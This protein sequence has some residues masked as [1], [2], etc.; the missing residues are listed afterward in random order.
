M[1]HVIGIIIVGSV[2]LFH[3]IVS[4]IAEIVSIGSN[5]FNGREIVFIY[6]SVPGP[7]YTIESVN[8]PH[9]NVIVFVSKGFP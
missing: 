8:K 3:S 4:I 7:P 2:L 9:V 6:A 5:L 1:L